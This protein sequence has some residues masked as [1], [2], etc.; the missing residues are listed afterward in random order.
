[1]NTNLLL[2]LFFV[3]G[4]FTALAGVWVVNLK[5]RYSFKW[6][7]WVLAFLSVAGMSFTLAWSF[8]SLVEYEPQA[9][10]L[11]LVFFGIPS[12]IL[13]LVTRRTLLKGDKS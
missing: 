4:A 5:D 12:V 2:L 1:M 13:A 6:Y 7:T 9:A 8:S 10:G 3:L 11:G